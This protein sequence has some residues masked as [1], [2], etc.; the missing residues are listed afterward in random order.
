MM[1]I[2][3]SLSGALGNVQLKPYFEG[4]KNWIDLKQNWKERSKNLV[5]T[6]NLEVEE[7]LRLREEQLKLKEDSD[8]SM[9]N[10]YGLLINPS[11]QASI[12]KYSSMYSD[13]MEKMML[14]GSRMK[15]YLLKQKEP[16]P[17]L[18]T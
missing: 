9:R 4:E 3:K 13:M 6:P 2:E 7:Q 15:E 8:S 5:K 12:D 10:I 1:E 18:Q 11:S 14:E 16:D 17:P